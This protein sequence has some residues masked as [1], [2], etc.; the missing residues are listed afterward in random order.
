[1]DVAIYASVCMSV[2]AAATFVA[3]PVVLCFDFI[4]IGGVSV[5]LIS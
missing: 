5:D 3:F 2:A 1:M 4:V